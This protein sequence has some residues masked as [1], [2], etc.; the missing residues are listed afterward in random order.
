MSRLFDQVNQLGDVGFGIFCLRCSQN[1]QFL[2][3][4]FKAFG[5]Y[6]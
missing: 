5:K 2:G 4:A 3:G 6:E 1:F